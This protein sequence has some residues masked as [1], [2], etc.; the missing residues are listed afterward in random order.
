MARGRVVSVP[1]G[2]LIRV[3]G[4]SVALLCSVT[5]YEGPSEQD[6][7]WMVLSGDTDAN[8]VHIISTF[9]TSFT[10][11]SLKERVAS[12]DILIQRLADSKVELRIKEVKVMDS[13]TYRCKTPSTDTQVVGN[14]EA[15]VQLKGKVN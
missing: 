8:A 12:G 14:Y 7:D 2:P 6:F 1:A 9:D 13:A 4:Q 10:D 15:D 3:E 11:V 5:D